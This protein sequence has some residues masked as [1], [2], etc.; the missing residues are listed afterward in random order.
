[1][2]LSL[3]VHNIFA[4]V[5]LF[6]EIRKKNA[7]KGVFLFRYQEYLIA[8]ESAKQNIYPLVY[9]FSVK[10][11]NSFTSWEYSIAKS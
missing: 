5:M 4:K 6:C 3:F 8:D 9:I 2:S 7:L 10:N 11:L 1:M